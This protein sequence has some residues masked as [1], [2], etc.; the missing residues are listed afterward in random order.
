MATWKRKPQE[1]E[2]TYRFNGKLYM[3]ATVQRELRQEEIDWI[4][5]DVKQFAAEQEGIDYLQVYEDEKHRKLFF[6]DQLNDE[7][8]TAHPP[9]HNY[10][11]LLFSW[12]Y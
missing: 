2:G 11:T 5:R 8:K 3:T 12:E 7:M 6:I 4:V 9:E 10:A 1:C